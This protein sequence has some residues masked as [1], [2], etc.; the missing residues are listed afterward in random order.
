[1][2]FNRLDYDTCAYKQ[3]LSESIGPGEYQW[4]TP[5]ISCQD[6][7]SR[8]PQLI[9]QRAGAK[10]CKKTFQWLMLIQN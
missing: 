8:D 10:C 6:C 5:H 3:E 9:L 7:F 1:M 4:G 2:S